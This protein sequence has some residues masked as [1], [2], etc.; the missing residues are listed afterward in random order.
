MG[1]SVHWGSPRWKTRSSNRR[2]ARSS[3]RST[4]NLGVVLA[5][6]ERFEAAIEAFQRALRIYP[7]L[8]PLHLNLGLAYYKTGNRG[9]AIGQSR[10]N[11]QNDRGNRQA[12]QQLATSL[13]ESDKYAEAAQ[14]FESLLPTEDFS[15]RLGLATPM[16]AWAVPTRPG[17]SSTGC[18]ATI[19][20]EVRL[21][22]RQAYLAINGFE[23][24][25]KA[26]R[27]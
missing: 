9:A 24:A 19:S 20:A 6:Q 13:L 21:A 27:N 18:C 14:L 15:V 2:W 16:L 12:R 22:L 17:P 11:L 26:F 5:R 3:I 23:D 25:E 10:L 4:S 8:A 1:D 7:G